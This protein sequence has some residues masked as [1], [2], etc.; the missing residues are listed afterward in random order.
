MGMSK[1]GIE[2]HIREKKLAARVEAAVKE[3]V[4]C[5]NIMG[6]EEIVATAIA[7]EL[8]RTHRTL[9]SSFLGA[10]NGAMVTYSGIPTDARN[11]AA[12]DYAKKIVAI[13]HYFPYI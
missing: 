9:Q 8:C 5:V 12:V 4:D 10:F 7:N 2:L 11:E 13:D 6:S 3:I 1:S